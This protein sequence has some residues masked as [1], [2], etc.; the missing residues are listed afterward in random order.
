MSKTLNWPYV[1]PRLSL[2]IITL[3]LVVLA[4]A[5]ALYWN[6]QKSNAE[7]QLALTVMEAV[8]AANIVVGAADLRPD[9]QD[10]NTQQ[11][12]ETLAK[13]ADRLRAYAHIMARTTGEPGLDGKAPALSTRQALAATAT[14]P[15]KAV[16]LWSRQD[17]GQSP[18]S[19]LSKM[20]T[21]ASALAADE[22]V[23]GAAAKKSRRQIA[24]LNSTS[25]GPALRAIRDVLNEG[26]V[27]AGPVS[28][29]LLVLTAVATIVVAALLFAI[30]AAAMI[31]RSD[32]SAHE[33]GRGTGIALAGTAK[34][35]G[36]RIRLDVLAALD[37][38]IRTSMNGVVG[39]VDMLMRTELDDKQRTYVDVI[40][41][42]GAAL[43]GTIENVIDY[44]RADCGALNLDPRPFSLRECVQSVAD[45]M[46]AEAALKGVELLIRVSKDLPDGY[47]GDV[48][49]VRQ[50]MTALVERA[51]TA[52]DGGNVM[53]DIS[54]VLGSAKTVSLAFNARASNTDI[55]GNALAGLFDAPSQ[56]RD[57]VSGGDLRLRLALSGRLV[58]LMNG[59]VSAEAPSGDNM[60][61]SATMSLPL[62]TAQTAAAE[63]FAAEGEERR[64]L[65]IDD[66]AATRECL[67]EAAT[68]MGFSA[69]AAE[70]G[71]LGGL[72]AN[73]M[74]GLDKPLDVI[75][76]DTD[77]GEEDGLEVVQDLKADTQVGDAA[78]VLM[79]SN[80]EPVPQD[81][82]M[83]TGVA[84]AF[85]KP[86][87]PL[88]LAA[89][90][91]K[92]LAGPAAMT[93]DQADQPTAVKPA[94]QANPGKDALNELAEVVGHLP[95]H[96]AKSIND[97]LPL[98]VLVAEDNEVNQLVFSQ[99]LEGLDLRFRIAVN[100]RDAVNDF[101]THR[102]MIVLMDVSMPEMNGLDA[103]RAI[104]EFE[105]GEGSHTP[106]IGVT[107]HSLRGDQ[108]KCVEA[109]MD[110]YMAKPISP[111]MIGAKIG[112][113]ME[114]RQPDN[115]RRR[116][117]N[118]RRRA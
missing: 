5:G 17:N 105:A 79:M 38:E 55:G 36:D 9:A 103:T 82:A 89:A 74:A 117:A 21:T 86:A 88:R 109:G 77:L 115:E 45:A 67:V 64:L 11:R 61:L 107:A 72:F 63:K 60:V 108:Q 70:S 57:V 118:E 27:A 41:A 4:G 46:I 69:V 80:G 18:A 111:D 30:M 93:I 15:A 50:V 35:K 33:P 56:E 37:G 98:Q 20:V 66:N 81:D 91:R 16:A 75:L 43:R 100:G 101:K 95:E 104:R 24:R 102:P 32:H 83:P 40:A 39:T 110:D 14:M 97:D 68:D 113:W 31:R 92:A 8:D 19:A 62:D 59:K 26:T 51:I 87:G 6:L 28:R 73:H 58:R 22:S 1:W 112:K 25:V 96:V 44:A 52:S 78:L 53:I 116:A 99:I 76:I 65:V 29:T 7:T 48:A 85:A 12:R 84:T 106:I 2:Q 47:V 10:K 42:S 71:R 23:S 13:A 90:L 49:R 114:R 3:A 54:G 34:R 94:P